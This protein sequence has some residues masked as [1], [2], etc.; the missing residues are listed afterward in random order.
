VSGLL[1]W[2]LACVLFFAAVSCAVFGVL[3]RDH[4]NPYLSW[5]AFVAWV[6][7]CIALAL[8]LRAGLL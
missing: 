4:E 5:I 8:V 1:L 6:V 3:V 2:V 7:L